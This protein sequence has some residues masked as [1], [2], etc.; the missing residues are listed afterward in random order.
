METRGPHGMDWLYSSY[1]RGEA[2]I[3]HDTSEKML[4]AY[5]QAAPRRVAL[6]AESEVVPL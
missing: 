2:R 4:Y 3:W 1:R 6:L 5:V